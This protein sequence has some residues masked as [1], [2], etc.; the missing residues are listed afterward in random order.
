MGATCLEPVPLL[1][2]II[3]DKQFSLS[4]ASHIDDYKWETRERDL[5]LVGNKVE[6]IQCFIGLGPTDSPG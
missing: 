5:G 3:S 2:V 6:Y 1:F 4:H